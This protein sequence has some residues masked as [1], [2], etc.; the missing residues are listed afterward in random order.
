MV[1]EVIRSNDKSRFELF[2][3]ETFPNLFYTQKLIK[4]IE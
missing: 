1:C 2:G 4:L 3:D